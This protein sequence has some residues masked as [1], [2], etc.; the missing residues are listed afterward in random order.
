MP[1]STET[2]KA[3]LPGVP[4]GVRFE[5]IILHT[6]LEQLWFTWVEDRASVK[7]LGTSRGRGSLALVVFGLI[8]IS[9]FVI[10]MIYTF[11]LDGKTSALYLA[12][13]MGVGFFGLVYVF[14]CEYFNQRVVILDS[15]KLV[16]I[17]RPF[18]GFNSWKKPISTVTRLTF[19]DYCLYAEFSDGEKRFLLPRDLSGERHAF[20]KDKIENELGLV[21]ETGSSD[22][23]EQKQMPAKKKSLP[24]KK[25]W[26]C[27]VCG[28]TKLKQEV[29]TSCGANPESKVPDGVQV[30]RMKLRPGHMGLEITVASSW[31]FFGFG[32][33]PSI[34]ALVLPGSVFLAGGKAAFFYG[35]ILLLPF[36]FLFY[37]HLLGYNRRIIFVDSETLSVSYEPIPRPG[38]SRPASKIVKFVERTS[39]RQSIP[40]ENLPMDIL[41]VELSKSWRFPKVLDNVDEKTNRFV[42]QTLKTVLGKDTKPLWK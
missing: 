25:S 38:W 37:I 18:P 16:A 9:V 36:F 40:G 30:K 15:E 39:M 34:F 6:G 4:E 21:P 35:I 42:Q 22:T 23:I 1:E 26:T 10:E 7:W 28:T 14:L 19:D 41:E 11:I 17:W 33:L 27:P 20:V 12:I 29:C 5:E 24:H 3:V 32:I 13:M 8:A 2:T 31:E